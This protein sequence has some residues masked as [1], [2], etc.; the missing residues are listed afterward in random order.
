MWGKEPHKDDLSHIRDYE[1]FI[2]KLNLINKKVYGSLNTGGRH[3]IL[4]GD[5]RKKG[6]Y[7]SIIKDMTWYGE[8]EAHLIKAQH[9]T[10]GQSKKYTRYNFIPIAH[11][12]IMVFVKPHV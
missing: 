4:I 6:K 12:H 9:N 2:Q 10:R 8:L 7:Y 5:V 1:E 11:E 3:V